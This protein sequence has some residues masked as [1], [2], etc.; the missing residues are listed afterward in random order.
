MK[1]EGKTAL[2]TGADSGIG[3]A[4]AILF[5]QEGADVVI[6]YGHDKTG[7]EETAEGVRQHGRRAEVIQADLADP[8]SA[9]RLFAQALEEF[10]HLD[11]VVNNAGTGPEAETSLEDPLDDFIRVINVDLISPFAIAQAAAK[12]MIARGKGSIINVTSVHEDIPGSG[13]AYDAAKG[14]LRNVTRSLVKELAPKGVR[15]N[16]IA[17]GMIATP[18]TQERL[19]DPEQAKQSAEAIPMRRAGLPLE[20]ANVALFLASDAA[21]Y[22]TGSSYFVDGGLM[23]TRGG[24]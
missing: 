9:Q 8:Q 3:Q 15:I 24:A 13:A 4:T 18:M 14:G 11:I 6:H 16:N 2:V 17:P 21:S 20:V 12:H 5:A 10:G 19:E 7:A 23:Q 22:V 1:L